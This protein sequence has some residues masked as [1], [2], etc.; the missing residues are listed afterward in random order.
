MLGPIGF[1]TVFKSAGWIYQSLERMRSSRV[2]IKM[3]H[4]IIGA[5]YSFEFRL[6]SERNLLRHPRLQEHAL[7]ASALPIA[8][9]G[10]FM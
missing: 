6:Q 5:I 8:L 9:E 1:D 10:Y 3:S 7:G 2:F 4:V